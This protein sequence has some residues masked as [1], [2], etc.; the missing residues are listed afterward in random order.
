MKR[1]RK[2]MNVSFV[3]LLIM[4]FTVGIP[5]VYFIY[6]AKDINNTKKVLREA[7]YSGAL[8]GTYAIDINGFQNGIQAGRSTPFERYP[9]DSSTG[10]PVSFMQQLS[11]SVRWYNS[12][13]Y[14]INTN[15][16]L[17][18]AAGTRYPGSSQNIASKEI[19]ATVQ[20]YLNANLNKVSGGGRAVYTDDDFTIAMSFEREG[21]VDPI[22]NASVD[23]N[24]A[25]YN[26]VTVS[27]V[28]NYKPTLLQS[29]SIFKD[30]FK[31]PIPIYG[32]SSAKTKTIL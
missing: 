14:P 1:F 29:L 12:S 26:K 17:G 18:G 3:L 10:S 31:D 9:I 15:D 2:S 22:S 4:V 11:K 28:L 25:P 8:A 16:C 30:T 19:V 23:D 5:V 32:T 13:S 20:E 6:T 7:A 27:V 24:N 21:L